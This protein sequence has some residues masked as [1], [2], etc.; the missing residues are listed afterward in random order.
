M[1][2]DRFGLILLL[3]FAVAAFAGEAHGENDEI[4]SVAVTQWTDQ[5]ELFMEYPL[6]VINEPGRFIIHLTIL[7]GFQPVREGGV[8]LVFTGPTGKTHEIEATELLREGIFVPSVELPE[9]GA[10]E[11]RLSYLGPE[12]RDTFHIDDF[13]VYPAA[14]AIKAE[15]EEDADDEIVFLKEQ[16]WKIPFATAEAEVREIKRAV[17]AIG[18][19]LPSPR[20]YAEIVAP[21]DGIV[22]IAANDNLALPG[23]AVRRGDVLA[24]ITPPM[25][26]DSWV[27]SRLAFE[28]AKRNYERAERL[29]ELDAISEREFEETRNEFQARKAGFEN[30]EGAGIVALNLKAPISGKIIE[31]TARPGQLVRAGDKLMAVADPSVVWLKVNVYENDFRSLGRPVGAHVNAGAADGG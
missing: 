6:L 26:G 3:I 16:Q 4:P 20:A 27:D 23:S 29:K 24:T 10:Y 19:V 12:V 14:D 2:I 31:W 22:Q 7:D 30:L 25:Q 18:E 28:Q 1:R 13:V 5:M 11:F 17:W 15:T 8:S 9:P 21:V